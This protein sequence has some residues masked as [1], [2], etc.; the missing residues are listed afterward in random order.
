M[1]RFIGSGSILTQLQTVE[2]PTGQYRE[3]FLYI[4]GTNAGGATLALTSMNNLRINRNGQ[5][6]INCNIDNISALSDL[7]A[8]MIDAASAI[9][10]AFHFG[11]HIPFYVGS[12]GQ[13]PNILNVSDEDNVKVHFDFGALAAIVAS[14]TFNL[15]GRPESGI[16]NY[17]PLLIQDAIALGAAG[18]QEKRKA[19]IQNIF[20]CYA[21][22][23]TPANFAKLEVSR[24]NQVMTDANYADLAAYTN[25]VNRKEATAIA[26]AEARVAIALRPDE[27]LSENIYVMP[28]SQTG[29]VTIELVYSGAQ[30]DEKSTNDS[31]RALDQR[32]SQNVSTKTNVPASVRHYAAGPGKTGK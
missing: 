4:S 17:V 19:S 31:G 13:F 26:V 9:G 24:D 22:P 28:S 32:V 27:L 30:F 2:I 16:E 3:L 25:L 10:A 15:W 7:L 21:F 8:G 20:S 5:D 29:A 12:Y 11:F 18:A 14:G 1:L 6:F 23:N